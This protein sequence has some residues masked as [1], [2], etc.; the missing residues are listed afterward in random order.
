MGHVVPAVLA[1]A[2]EC[3]EAW[4]LADPEAWLRVFGKAPGLPPDPEALWG[5]P[6]EANSNHPK[7]VLRRCLDEI[8]RSS[9]GNAV[10]RLLEQTSLE[11][12]ATRCPRGFGRF[13]ADLRRAFPHIE[14][15]VAAA[16]DS[17]I[18]LDREPPWGFDT[19]RDHVRDLHALV[20][21]RSDDERC[22]VILGRKTWERLPALP[23][24]AMDALR[25]VAR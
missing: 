6:R 4:A 15:L 1:L 3:I 9:A 16:T 5:D 12:L 2:I 10:A 18:G 19:L 13:V 25:R 17:A 8:G 7:C 20:T 14:C 21:S 24:R 11:R 22:A 23:S